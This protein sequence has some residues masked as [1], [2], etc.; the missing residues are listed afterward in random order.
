MSIQ[1]N[2]TIVG[3]QVTEARKSYQC[4]VLGNDTEL[5]LA[6]K[7]TGETCP[8][9]FGDAVYF[10]FDDHDVASR[11]YKTP[12]V[13]DAEKKQPN[14]NCAQRFGVDYV[15]GA[16]Y[17]KQNGTCMHESFDGFKNPWSPVECDRFES[18]VLEPGTPTQ[19]YHLRYLTIVADCQMPRLIT[20]NMIDNTF[21]QFT[22]IDPTMTTTS[23]TNT[24]TAAEV[25]QLELLAVVA[26]CVGGGTFLGLVISGIIGIIVCVKCRERCICCCKKKVAQK[27][28]PSATVPRPLQPYDLYPEYSMDEKTKSIKVE[29]KEEK[30]ARK[31]KAKKEEG[32]KV[33]EG[34]DIKQVDCAEDSLGNVDENLKSMNPLDHMP[35]DDLENVKLV[36]DPAFEGKVPEVIENIRTYVHFRKLG[37]GGFGAVYK[38][39]VGYIGDEFVAVKFVM[40]SDVDEL[41]Y[42]KKE[43]MVARQIE[44]LLGDDESFIVQ[45]LGVGR[46]VS[47][48]Y[49]IMPFYYR[50]MMFLVDQDVNLELQKKLIVGYH[51]LRPI[52]QLQKVQ[53]AHLDLKLENYMQKNQYSNVCILCDF[54]VARRF[55]S[56]RLAEG[57]HNYMSVPC[58]KR[59]PV[60]ALDDM[61]SWLITLVYIFQKGVPWQH[62]GNASNNFGELTEKG[63]HNDEAAWASKLQQK[64][65]FFADVPRDSVQNAIIHDL[66]QL[67]WFKDSKNI[68]MKEVLAYMDQLQ[69]RLN[70]K[71]TDYWFDSRVT[72]KDVSLRQMDDATQRSS[73]KSKRAK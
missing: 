72:Y 66:G 13:I 68:N 56:K 11:V 26:A 36:D 25:D 14:I 44:R 45:I 39:R 23:S 69:A 7:C 58:H 67:I 41:R 53:Y 18:I 8:Y 43:F 3:G 28:A 16:F 24:T 29:K 37:Q 10:I 64:N 12:G 46:N 5:E 34:I 40:A 38:Y 65:W 9:L 60:S 31:K 2:K 52:L 32:R 19:Y 21:V 57:T 30:K 48:M 55:G 62:V 71:Y 50:T 59:Q 1:G 47:T 35:I 15:K 63:L 4:P 73:R 61:Q 20:E 27:K 51:L 54:G 17:F 33:V 22:Y 49:M 70:F 6:A 42:A